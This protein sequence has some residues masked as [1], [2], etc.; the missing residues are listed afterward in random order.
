MIYP[1]AIPIDVSTLRS[2]ALRRVSV[3]K[4]YLAINIIVHNIQLH[5]HYFLLA[6]LKKFGIRQHSDQAIKPIL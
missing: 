5:S 3:I 6:G 2:A 1:I 4:K